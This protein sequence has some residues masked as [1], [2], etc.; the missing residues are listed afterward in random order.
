IV[1]FLYVTV[2][3][4]YAIFNRRSRVDE[5]Q[6]EFSLQSLLNDLHVEK[7]KVTNTISKT[8]CVRSLRC[9]DECRIVHFEFLNCVF[10]L[11]IVFPVY[12]KESGKYH[13][14]CLAVSR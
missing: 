4:R 9:K 8:K 2:C 5:I 7:T 11:L 6:I 12:G 3:E 10:Q 13:R 1:H 14:L